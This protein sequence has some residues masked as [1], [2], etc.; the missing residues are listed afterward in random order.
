[1]I[2]N[3]FTD[4][5]LRVKLNE[6]LDALTKFVNS[7][8]DGRVKSN[9]GG[10]QSG[11][12]DLTLPALQSLN[13]QILVHGSN[14]IREVLQIH[15]EV[16]INNLWVN[17]NYFKDYNEQ[18]VHLDCV[19]SGVFYVKTNPQAGDLKFFRSNSLDVW[20]PDRIITTFNSNNATIWNFKSE[21]NILMLFPA[22]LKHSVTPNLS[23]E[24]RISISFNLSVK[25]G[26]G[27]W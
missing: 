4:P 27:L 3:L 23:Q 18:H 7:L 5:V 26:R 19:L 2:T 13:Y 9:V 8:Q 17:K 24:E 14:F 25:D 12:L 15:K 21:D 11:D 22:W 16:Y 10:F 1:M 6:D 20:A